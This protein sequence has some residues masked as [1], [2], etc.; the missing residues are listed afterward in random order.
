MLTIYLLRHGQTFWNADN[1][2]YC[3]RSDIGLT[4]LGYSQAEEARNQ[5]EGLKFDAIYSS[6]LQRA[7][8]TATIASGADKDSTIRIVKD[9]RLIES[10]FGTWEGK[11]KDEFVAENEQYWLDWLKDPAI[12]P[13]GGTGESATDLLNRVNDFYK[14]IQQNHKSGNILIVAHNNVNRFFMAQ[15]LGMPLRNYRQL[16]QHNSAVT[17]FTLDEEGT[18][19]LE[20]LNTRLR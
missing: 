17:C 4:E 15:K 11:T 19:T 9:V 14:S 10:D 6:P 1:N 5:L 12:Y 13:A 20:Y 8:I 16:I 18:L 2:R 3:G 7:Y